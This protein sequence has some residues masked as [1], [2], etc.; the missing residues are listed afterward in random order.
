MIKRGYQLLAVY[1]VAVAAIRP[2]LSQVSQSEREVRCRTKAAG[3]M[4]NSDRDASAD[5]M[6]AMKYCPDTGAAMYAR[7]WREPPTD[8]LLLA[9]LVD[10][11]V[12]LLDK[13]ILDA[14]L[15]ASANRRNALE[16]RVAAARVAWYY[17]EPMSVPVFPHPDSVRTFGA[18]W[19]GSYVSTARQYL[20]GSEPLPPN[21]R[22]LVATWA[23]EMA[24]RPGE[25]RYIV[26]IFRIMAERFRCPMGVF[27]RCAV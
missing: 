19:V 16:V 22:H 5:A 21:T 3:L 25:N 2:A 10:N 20:K 24:D 13:R 7:R 26:Q 12:D 6:A 4:Q 14:V 23:R 18:E 9:P 15:A 17:A 1:L 11:S 8:L 27:G